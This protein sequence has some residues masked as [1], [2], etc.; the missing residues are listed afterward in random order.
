MTAGL[1]RQAWFTAYFP[2]LIN[3][4]EAAGFGIFNPVIHLH[5]LMLFVAYKTHLHC[6]LH[7]DFV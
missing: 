2:S 3:N 7:V 4:K 6:C 5:E 1:M